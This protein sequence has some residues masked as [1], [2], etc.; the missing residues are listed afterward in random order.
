MKW[1]Q[2]WVKCTELEHITWLTQPAK[3]FDALNVIFYLPFSPSKFSMHTMSAVVQ[4]PENI[5]MYKTQAFSF[6][7]DI[8]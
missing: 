7:I 4:R 1:E 3:S 6:V 2:G 8:S 5:K